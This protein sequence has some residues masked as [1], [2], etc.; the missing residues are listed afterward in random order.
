MQAS[1]I[2]DVPDFLTADPC[3]DQNNSITSGN[4][5]GLIVTQNNFS[6]AMPIGSTVTNNGRTSIGLTKPGAGSLVATT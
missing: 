2:T 5:Q 4:G 1:R 6:S 3:F